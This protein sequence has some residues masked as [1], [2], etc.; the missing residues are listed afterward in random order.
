MILPG[1][2]GSCRLSNWT[3]QRIGSRRHSRRSLQLKS[4]PIADELPRSSVRD[5]L[6]RQSAGDIGVKITRCSRLNLPK[7]MRALETLLPSILVKCKSH[8]MNGVVW[9]VWTELIWH[10]AK[11]QVE[12][13]RRVT[14][15]S[16][17]AFRFRVPRRLEA[18]LPIWGDL[19]PEIEWMRRLRDSL[20][21]NHVL[22]PGD[23]WSNDAQEPRTK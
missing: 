16:T 11:T 7:L 21:P 6:K 13:C 19:G 2:R 20:D 4:R 8:V 10:D 12:R 9:A 22:N 1:G 5:W 14:E 17:A 3:K 15:D 18:S 23:S